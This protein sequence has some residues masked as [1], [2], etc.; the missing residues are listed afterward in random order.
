MPHQHQSPPLAT[1]LATGPAVVVTPGSPSSSTTPNPPATF[2]DGM[3]KIMGENPIGTA[4]LTASTALCTYHGYKRNDSVGWALAWGILGGMFPIIA[5]VV[6]VAQ[7]FAEPEAR[8]Q[9]LAA[10]GTNEFTEDLA[11]HVRARCA[12]CE[13]HQHGL[14]GQ[15]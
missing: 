6:A 3:L 5:P 15:K 13:L 2:T 12:A 8:Q 9:K 11:P 14:E 7:G 1:A 10:L 4:L